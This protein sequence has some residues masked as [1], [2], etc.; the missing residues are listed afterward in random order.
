M[1]KKYTWLTAP[2]DI[3]L[4]THADYKALEEQHS[5]DVQGYTYEI[6]TLKG[7]IDNLTA[8]LAECRADAE[9]MDQLELSQRADVY[10]HENG[11]QELAGYE[12]GCGGQYSTARDALDAAIAHR[13]AQESK[14]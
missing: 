13:K 9:R 8:E 5:A 11:D 7:E 6:D 3:H 1:I 2:E 10:W 4:V 12:W 14:A